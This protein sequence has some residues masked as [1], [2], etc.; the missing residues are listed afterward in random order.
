GAGHAH[1]R[2]LARVGDP[3]G[4][5]L[6]I[7]G[8][9]RLYA[10][11]RTGAEEVEDVLGDL[12]DGVLGTRSH[13]GGAVGAELADPP[14]RARRPDTPAARRRVIG[15]VRVARLAP[16]AQRRVGQDLDV[17][18]PGRRRVVA[19]VLGSDDLVQAVTP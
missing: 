13:V 15:H 18:G 3:D 14:V 10:A 16:A 8:G 4:Q 6:Q 1:R 19:V 9:R 12:H 11:G 7:G 17:L 2:R 5:V